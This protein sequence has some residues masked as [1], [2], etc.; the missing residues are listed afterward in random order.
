M[1]QRL[2][3]RKARH[4]FTLTEMLVVV[5]I[6]VVLAA[7]AVPITMSV[8]T[9]VKIDTATNNMK[10][11][12]KTAVFDYCRRYGKDGDFPA[13]STFLLGPPDGKG[14]LTRSVALD[15]WERPYTIEFLD[16]NDPD[17][18]IFNMISGGPSGN[19]PIVVSSVQ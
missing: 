9:Q 14:L 7:V 16:T 15:P 3:T 2:P 10:G 18:P 12:I 13:D 6:I 11:P 8:L 5:A 19:E 1:T 17:R 4:G